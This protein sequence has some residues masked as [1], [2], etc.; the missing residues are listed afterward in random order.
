VNDWA[1]DAAR[2]ICDLFPAEAPRPQS[3]FVAEVIRRHAG[4]AGKQLLQL[5]GMALKAIAKA[6][7]RSRP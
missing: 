2:E 1:Q 5:T 7:A 3:E 6:L 4:A